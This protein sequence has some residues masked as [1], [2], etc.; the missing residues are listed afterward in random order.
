[1][2]KRVG[3]NSSPAMM[4]DALGHRDRPLGEANPT[5]LIRLLP[6]QSYDV[7]AWTCAEGSGQRS[8]GVSPSSEPQ[9]GTNRSLASP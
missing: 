7:C 5:A 1:M 8:G 4:I 2:R 9:R 6:A 3:E